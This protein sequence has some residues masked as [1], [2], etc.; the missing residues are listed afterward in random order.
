M[1]LNKTH[2]AVIV[3]K[4]LRELRDRASASQQDLSEHLQISRP[5]L[6]AYESGKQ[7]ISVAEAYLAAEYFGVEISELVPSL[8]QI[9]QQTS[10][11]SALARKGIVGDALKDVESFI[12]EIGKDEK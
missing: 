4:K 11:E 5:T 1:S 2:I 8:S 6:V 12:S 7:S 9:K 10:L 3:G